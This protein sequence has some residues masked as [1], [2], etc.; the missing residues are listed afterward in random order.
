MPAYRG[1]FS[2]VWSI[3]NDEKYSGSTLHFIDKKIDTIG[4]YIT[5]EVAKELNNIREFTLLF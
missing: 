5:N 4:H 1:A 3:I 2:S